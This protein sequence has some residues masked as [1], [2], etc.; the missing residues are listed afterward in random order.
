MLR[1]GRAKINANVIR[2]SDMGC[3]KWLNVVSKCQCELVRNSTGVFLRDKNSNGI[4]V[5]GN[6]VGKD[7]MWPLLNNSEIRFTGLNKN[8]FVIMLMEVTSDHSN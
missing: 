2:K 4:L 5:N 8:V 1:L 6:K 7:N 3:S